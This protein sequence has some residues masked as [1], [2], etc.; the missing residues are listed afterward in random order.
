MVGNFKFVVKCC[1]S[2]TT[3]SRLEMRYSST[4]I[5]IVCTHSHDSRECT[6]V[7]KRTGSWHLSGQSQ[8]LVEAADECQVLL[9]NDSRTPRS[10]VGRLCRHLQSW[11]FICV[12]LRSKTKNSN[13]ILENGGCTTTAEALSVHVIHVH[14]YSSMFVVWHLKIHLS[15]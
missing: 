3:S 9:R 6:F 8:P 10:R 1:A 2:A 13:A 14:E 11:I 4:C 5:R 12:R 15:Q 7:R